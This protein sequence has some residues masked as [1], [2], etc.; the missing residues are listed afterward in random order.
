MGDLAS[1]QL[2]RTVSTLAHPFKG[3]D[4]VYGGQRLD[5]IE[6]ADAD[7]KHCTFA[8]LSFKQARFRNGY[9]QNCIFIGCYFRRAEL[10][11]TR[12]IGCR[13]FD[14]VFSH[15][16]V[17]G[18]NFSFS[19]F[20]D[21]CVPFAEMRYSLPQEPNIREELARNLALES[22]HLGLGSEARAYRLEEIR[23]REEHLLGAIFARSQWYQEHFDFVGRVRAFGNLVFSLLNRWFWG[24]GERARV[25]LRNLILVGF[26]IFPVFFFF[27]KNQLHR[28]DNSEVTILDL[29]FFSMGN[30]VPA[31]IVSGVVAVGITARLLA[32]FES[33]IGV[34]ALGL[35]A[36]Y[37]FRWSL[38]R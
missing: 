2:G 27:V 31:G 3:E 33:V 6:I 11:S 15:V 29:L 30:I 17:R 21:C 32:S 28:T 19:T 25:L 13:F 34:V 14:C 8:N 24:Y 26:V 22:S 37:I 16:A 36:S 20:R 18:C 4:N 10:A 1:Y 38:H 9:F 7:F 12:F 23:A 5:A 35:F